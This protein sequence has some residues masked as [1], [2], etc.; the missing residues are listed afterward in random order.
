MTYT[1]I[2]YILIIY[3]RNVQT[4]GIM[5]CDNNKNTLVNVST[6]NGTA[7]APDTQAGAHIRMNVAACACVCV[8]SDRHTYAHAQTRLAAIIII[9]RVRAYL[10]TFFFAYVVHGSVMCCVV[11]CT[12]IAGVVCLYTIKHMRAR[13]L[14][15][16]RAC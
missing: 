13:A 8:N 4:G 2:I 11:L 3:N 12:F 10:M 14:T 5:I 6:T 9:I 1:L 16:T 15:G 7:T